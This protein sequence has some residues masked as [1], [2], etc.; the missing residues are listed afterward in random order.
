MTQVYALRITQRSADEEGAPVTLYVTALSLK[1]LRLHAQVDRW[2]PANVEGYQRPPVDR[3]LRDVAK[4]M[5][6][7]YGILPTSVLLGTRGD[8]HVPI[9]FDARGDS[10][11]TG[12][13]GL[14]TVPETAK[15]WIV[16][17]QHRYFGVN[18]AYERG[19]VEALDS[20][21]FPVTIMENIDRYMEMVHFNLI[22][23][24]QRKMPT[25]IVDRHLIQRQEREGLKMI[26]SGKRG[27][28]EYLQATATRIVDLL[29]E[30]PG[31]WHHQI[32]IPG[33]SWQRPRIAEATCLGSISGA[34][35]E[36][37]LGTGTET[38]RRARREAGHQLLGCP[39]RNLAGGLR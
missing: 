6:E 36:G 14:L 3:R 29:N 26:A 13:W 9:E 30:E 34:S 20:Y 31:P 25:D 2:T 32:A 7:E 23:T 15:L 28:K 16:D 8:D 4:Y 19:G 38:P 10:D 18:H 21:P 11:D 33:S 5:T 17:G 12:E 39:K 27:E 1:K 37:Y 24:R 35:D 22:N